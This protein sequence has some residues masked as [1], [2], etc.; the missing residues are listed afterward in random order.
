MRYRETRTESFVIDKNSSGTFERSFRAL[1]AFI[2]ES[3]VPKG[4]SVKHF[5]SGS[6]SG[7]VL[8][9]GTA[10]TSVRSYFAP[11]R[12]AN[13][14]VLN[15]QPLVVRWE[16]LPTSS[17][18]SI[19]QFLA[20]LDDTLMLF[21]RRFWR[22]LT[23]GSFTWGVLPFVNDMK[24]ILETIRN[25]SVS[26]EVVN[27]EDVEKFALFVPYNGYTGYTIEGSSRLQG[28]LDLSWTGEAQIWLDRLGFHPDIGTVWDLI[29]LSFVVDWILPVGD[30]I[31]H[32]YDRGWVKTVPFVGWRSVKFEG[33]THV[34]N[35]NNPYYLHKGSPGYI[36]FRYYRRDRVRAILDVSG[37][38]EIDFS[39]PSPKQLFNMLY[40]FV[41]SKKTN[42]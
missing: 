4:N 38:N 9:S 35:G 17:Q 19:I 25:L 39:L 14:A 33:M 13:E 41:L 20:E 31:S 37:T 36:P 28:S 42:L 7:L 40:I 24:A 21:T 16:K 18:F 32:F 11:A 12:I 29:P 8:D 15:L 10:S 3:S 34:F 27:Y 5:S 1:E 6:W 2:E 22:S 23:Y 26:L 30:F